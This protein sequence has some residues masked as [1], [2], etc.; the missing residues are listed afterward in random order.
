MIKHLY[1]ARIDVKKSRRWYFNYDTLTVLAN[2]DAAKAIRKVERAAKKM[3]VCNAVRVTSIRQI[4]A[5]DI[6]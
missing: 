2:G 5:V 4:A 6:E 1:E 3:H